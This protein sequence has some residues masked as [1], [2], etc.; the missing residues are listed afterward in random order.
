MLLLQFRY[1]PSDGELI[2]RTRRDLG[3]CCALEVFTRD[4]PDGHLPDPEVNALTSGGASN[5]IL[6]EPP[7]EPLGLA[8][9]TR[10][11]IP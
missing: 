1:N 6:I 7:R 10:T 9:A 11:G 8:G 2:T 3:L 4:R 5:K